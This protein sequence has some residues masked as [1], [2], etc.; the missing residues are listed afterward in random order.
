MKKNIE[1]KNKDKKKQKKLGKL[2]ISKKGKAENF[3]N[4]YKRALADYQNLLKRTVEEKQKFAKFANEQII[5][6]ILP[7]YDNLK[8]S[9]THIDDDA[10]NNGWAEGIKYVVKQFSDVLNNLGVV[11]I[12]AKGKKFDP[13]T[14][15]ALEGKGNKVKKVIKAGYLFKEKVIMPAKVKL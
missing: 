10:Q 3:E 9:L 12:K 5:L 4:M 8:V 7:V 6:E 14:M 2:K 15:E 13:Q 1:E 11:E